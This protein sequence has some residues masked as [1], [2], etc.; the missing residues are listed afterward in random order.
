MASA[1]DETEH[2]WP[3]QSW[4]YRDLQELMTLDDW[5]DTISQVFLKNKNI[6]QVHH[7]KCEGGG[8]YLLDGW[9]RLP[10]LFEFCSQTSSCEEDRRPESDS[11]LKL[12]LYS[13]TVT[14][15]VTKSDARQITVRV[16]EWERL[17][18]GPMWTLDQVLDINSTETLQRR[19]K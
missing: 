15:S 2:S 18:L 7:C 6:A 10:A 8:V 14:V 3:G 17:T 19:L 4:I 12:H 11:M 9:C 5:T 1:G 16:E 13:Y